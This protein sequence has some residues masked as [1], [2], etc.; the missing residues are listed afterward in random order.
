MG[1]YPLSCGVVRVVNGETQADAG[2]GVGQVG[3]VHIVR[4]GAFPGLYELGESGFRK[5]VGHHGA[6]HNCAQ[7][8]VGAYVFKHVGQGS[9]GLEGHSRQGIEHC[10]MPEALRREAE[11]HYGSGSKL[12]GDDF[13]AVRYHCLPEVDVKDLQAA[14]GQDTYDDFFLFLVFHPAV[15]PGHTGEG[16]LG[17]VVLGGAEAAGADY[18]VVL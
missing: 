7:A 8:E 13:A 18:N 5:A 14:G 1:R 16:F 6:V 15:C 11:H 10:G 3:Q 2:D 12:V 17:D 4:K 9:K